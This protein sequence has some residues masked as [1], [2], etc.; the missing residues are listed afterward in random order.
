MWATLDSYTHE[1]VRYIV[2]RF[3]KVT[4]IPDII[5]EMPFPRVQHLMAPQHLYRYRSDLFVYRPSQNPSQA[6]VEVT[7]A[8]KRLG[9][10]PAA[11][12][13]RS[14]QEVIAKVVACGMM[15]KQRERDIECM[16]GHVSA[17]EWPVFKAAVLEFR[18][19]VTDKML[20]AGGRVSLSRLRVDELPG[21]LRMWLEKQ[22]EEVS[23]FLYKMLGRTFVMRSNVDP[24]SEQWITADIYVSDFLDQGVL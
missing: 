14:Q 9:K 23:W 10:C 3:P 12:V 7:E 6:T 16:E 20:E 21:V 24:V 8:G 4:A 15:D 13:S 17:E 22:G 18:K 1:L 11:D 5:A 2:A 19:S